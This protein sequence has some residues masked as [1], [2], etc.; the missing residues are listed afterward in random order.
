MIRGC[1][2]VIYLYINLK[3][4]SDIGDLSPYFIKLLLTSQ[5]ILIKLLPTSQGILTKLL[6]TSQGILTKLLPTSQGILITTD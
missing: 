2:E 4:S 6:P 5:G 1:D 3:C